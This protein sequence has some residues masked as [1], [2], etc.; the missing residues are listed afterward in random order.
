VKR[1]SK[2]HSGIIFQE[3]GHRSTES[4]INRHP[5]HVKLSRY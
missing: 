2:F 3:Q 1:T 5:L 4:K